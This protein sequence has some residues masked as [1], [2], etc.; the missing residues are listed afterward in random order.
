MNQDITPTPP[1]LEEHGQE[2]QANS[3]NNDQRLLLTLRFLQEKAK[4]HWIWIVLMLAPLVTFAPIVFGGYTLAQSDVGTDSRL[5]G[6]LGVVPVMDPAGSA[7]GDEPILVNLRRELAHG[8]LPLLNMKNGLGTSS[9]ESPTASMFYIFNPLLLLL[10]TSSSLSYD[11][12]QLFHVYVFLIGFYLLLKYY[13]S[14]IAAAATGI[15][16]A[17]SGLTFV[18]VNIGDYRNY[19][20][21]P[22]MIAGAV[23]LARQQSV[24]WNSMIFVLAAVAA[25]TGGNLQH[26]GSEL[27]ATLVVYISE[28]LVRGPKSRAARLAPLMFMTGAVLISAI[29]VAPYFGSIHDGNLTV[30]NTPDR[31]VRPYDVVWMFSWFMP[32]IAGYYPYL[33]LHNRPYWPHSDLSTVAFLFLVAAL[34]YAWRHRRQYFQSPQLTACF[35]IP[36]VI[37]CGLVKVHHFQFLNFFSSI[38]LVQQFFFIK[39]HHYLFVLAAIPMGIGLQF[40][41]DLPGMERRRLLLKSAAIVAGIIVLAIVYLWARPDYSVKGAA[42][43]SVIQAVFIMDYGVAVGVFLVATAL[44]FWMPRHWEKYLLAVLVVQ[45]L[46][47]LPFGFHGRRSSSNATYAWHV[48]WFPDAGKRLLIHE[49]AESN[50]FFGVE[51]ISAFDPAIN[52]RYRQFMHTFFRFAA[53]DIFYQPVDTK[54]SEAQVRALQLAGVQGIFGYRVEASPLVRPLGPGAVEVLDPLPRV[55]VVSNE[56]YRG[57]GPFPITRQSVAGVLARIRRDLQSIPQ[58]TNVWVKNETLHFT[59]P[60][61]AA[62]VL[63]ANQAYSTNWTYRGARPSVFMN[64]WPAWQMQAATG[65]GQVVSFWPEGL[66]VGLVLAF[67]GLIVIAVAYWLFCAQEKGARSKGPSV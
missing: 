32:R 37:A 57:I 49:T 41:I 52:T 1:F 28:M 56:T 63:V 51:S 48:A 58:P 43:D 59:A 15:L 36:L 6:N 24:R 14:D 22:L 45:S 21:G 39:Y 44:L 3:Q 60:S 2:R 18:T 25:G 9:S 40:I 4:L 23:G 33:F 29:A 30:T 61:T 50:L 20:W 67:C 17:L 34:L 46:C 54:L 10:P 12:F 42:P 26:F 53:G 31:S 64:L 65:S 27:L 5:Y 55:F 66:T 38:P 62:G 7:I 47:L 8:H 13:V 35:V 11:L 19:V 16:L